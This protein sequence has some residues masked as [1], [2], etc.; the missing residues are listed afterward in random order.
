MSG[1][2]FA[3]VV[4]GNPAP[5]GSKRAFVNKRSGRVSLVE[6]SKREKPWRQDVMEA[7]LHARGGASAL[8]GPLRM[9]LV[10]TVPKPKSAPKSRRT[11]PDRKPDVDKLLRSVLDALVSAGV[12][13]DDARVVDMTRLAKVFVGEDPE[14]LD[15]PGAR[16]AI[17]EM[18]AA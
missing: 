4:Y 1:R 8:D 15:A 14:A 13:A 12:I 17:S 7:A 3:V 5:K 16:I 18:R 2:S 11:W 6:S 9:R 10:F